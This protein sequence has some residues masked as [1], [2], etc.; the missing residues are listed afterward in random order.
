MTVEN[1]ANLT[2]NSIVNSNMDNMVNIYHNRRPRVFFFIIYLF[3]Q[4]RD[5]FL[6]LFLMKD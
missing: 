6:P 2:Q 4:Y 1:R 3:F 5:L